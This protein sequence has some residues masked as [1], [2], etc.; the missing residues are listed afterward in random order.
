M[1]Q[2]LFRTQNVI[3]R[4]DN[5]ELPAS[6]LLRV[7][8][9]EAKGINYFNSQLSAESLEESTTDRYLLIMRVIS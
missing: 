2:E 4:D 7:S 8:H 9:F 6:N 1:Y 3:T 5:D